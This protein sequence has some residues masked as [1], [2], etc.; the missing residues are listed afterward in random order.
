MK[1]VIV[2]S[3]TKAKTIGKFLG[4]TFKVESSYGHVR[5][6]P[7]NNSKA[8]D[9]KGGFEPHYE[10]SK[11][12]EDLV[13]RLRELSKKADEVL[14]ATDPDREGEAIA[15]HLFMALN[16]KPQKTKRIVFHEITKEAIEEAVAN[17]RD[18]DQNL[19]RAQEARRVLDRLVGFDLSGLIWKKVRYGLSAGRVQSPALRILMER[20]REIRTFKPENFWVLTANL[21]TKKKETLALIC[22]EEPREEKEAL[23]IVAAGRHGTWIIK[24]VKESEMK[25]NPR[26]P[27]TTSTLQQSASTRLGFSPSRT[28]MLAQKLYEAG[29]I[30]YMRTD[31]ISISTQSQK[32]IISYIEKKFG[33]NYVEARAYKTKSR[34]A[35]E[36]HEAIRPTT[37]AERAGGTAEQNALYRLIWQRAVSSQM[38]EA[39]LLKTRVAANI[40]GGMIPDFAMTGSR[41][42]FDG[43][44]R[45]DEAARGEDVEI[46][47]VSV[48]EE[49]HLV[50]ISFE[51]KQTEPPNRYTEAGLIKELEKRGI[52][53]PSTYASTMKTLSDRGYVTK[54]GKTLLPTDTGDVVSTFL[55]QNFNTYVSDTFTAEMEDELDEI[56]DGKR[57]YG[58]TLKDFYG[59]F[60]KEVKSKENIEKLTNLGD[61]PKEFVCPK[62]GS[63]MIMKLGKNGIFMSCS[64][65]PECTGARTHEGKIIEPEKP[66]GEDP[67]SGLPVFVLNG[68]FGPYVQIG[69]K[70]KET[71]KPR[72]ASI[73][74]DVDPST[75]TLKEA[76]TYLSLPREVG[77]NP[78]TGKMI[79]A[80]IG[81]FGPYIVHD[82]DFRSL[83]K[84]DVY[85]IGLPRALEI[86]KEEKKKR[87]FRRTKK[88]K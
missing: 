20:E 11:G 86:L 21:E 12:K 66:I 19:R 32:Q 15:W 52:G 25:R 30:T 43:W 13:E 49:L 31:S 45:V 27:F 37:M 7:K 82:A 77:L 36:A 87:G 40:K 56:A 22:S 44:L 10:I 4:K 41:L 75:V 5:D 71:P 63:P 35:Q 79:T 47:K 74:K 17:P 54:N 83:K 81:R 70:T 18:I 78:D 64:R 2:E 3:P 62:C 50:E 69:Q 55:E 6:L 61:A 48:D 67:K 1:L 85:T 34:T 8:I 57:E 72:R 33:N 28:M 60:S 65:F 68:R 76:L 26:A 14:L 42:L 38:K 84:D 58:K 88:E 80:S 73:P 46:P 9:I 53:R 16:L 29:H 23:R 51:A 59:P 24:D 39:T